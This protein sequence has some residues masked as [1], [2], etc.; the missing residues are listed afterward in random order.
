MNGVLYLYKKQQP[1]NIPVG[2]KI[3]SQGLGNEV[4]KSAKC[5]KQMTESGF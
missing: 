3:V 5:E 2:M 4:N 1:S